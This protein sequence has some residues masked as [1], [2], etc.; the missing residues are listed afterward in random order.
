M[1][2]GQNLLDSGGAVRQGPTVE[3]IQQIGLSPR[4]MALILSCYP[5]VNWFVHIHPPSL[6]LP[7][8]GIPPLIL[9]VVVCAV[10]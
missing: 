9:H 4:H 5:Q 10:M 7:F 3:Y 6:D 1:Y 2:T 8:L